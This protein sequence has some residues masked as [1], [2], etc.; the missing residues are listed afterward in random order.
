LSASS[1]L[2]ALPVALTTALCLVLLVAVPAG[3][4][5]DVTGSYE[6][7]LEPAGTVTDDLRIAVPGDLDDPDLAWRVAVAGQ[8]SGCAGFTLVLLDGTGAEG[9]VLTGAR[10]DGD[11]HLEVEVRV[12]AADDQG[13]PAPPGNHRC[14]LRLATAGFTQLVEVTLRVEAGGDGDGTST[15][16]TTTTT[17]TLPAPTTTAPPT[18]TTVEE[19]TTTSSS[20]TTT[21]TTVL[22]P[23]AAAGGD[24]GGGLPFSGP[25]PLVGATVV[26]ALGLLLLGGGMVATSRRPPPP[27]PRRAGSRA[28]RLA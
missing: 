26:A 25:G 6:V 2:R 9:L 14:A 5:T 21:T 18:T 23:V 22:A 27:P 7:T 3:A 28:D 13:R 1:G 4:A 16:T 12:L 20:T 11:G 24:G 19:A 17:T 15:T 8:A 10:A